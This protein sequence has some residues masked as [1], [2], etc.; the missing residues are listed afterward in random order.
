MMGEWLAVLE[1]L[2]LVAALRDSTL[3]YPLV[4]A[5][6]LLGI[7]LLIGSIFTLDLKLLG[8]WHSVETHVLLDILRPVAATGMALAILTGLLLFATHGTEYIESRLFLIKLG[9]V[10]I[11]LINIALLGGKPDTAGPA[12]T[13]L[14]A[15]AIISL[16]TWLLAIV[17]G[18][19][20]GYFA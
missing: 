7:G 13:R 3:V 16:T 17:F 10:A 14:K 20:V 19:L 12:G 1:S 4:N 11:G 15:A 9:L 2:P 5:A 6:H 8:A 18:R